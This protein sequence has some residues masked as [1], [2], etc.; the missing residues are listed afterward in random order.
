MMSYQIITISGTPGSGKSTIA[1]QLAEKL[2]AQRV[3]VGGIRRELAKEKGMTLAELNEYAL[4]HPETDVDVDKKAAAKVKELAKKSPV[5]A[6]GRTM[7]HFL[8]ESIKIYVKAN[9]DV[10]AQRIWKA[11]QHPEAAEKRNEANVSSLDELKEKLHER[12]GSDIMRYK[13]YYNLDH[14]DLSQYDII[15]DTTDLSREESAQKTLEEINA[16]TNSDK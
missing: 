16:L 5:I 8:P 1:T 3:Y 12:E 4:S 7:F 6:E 9:F 11:L 15:I 13:K 2:N 14:T 10:G